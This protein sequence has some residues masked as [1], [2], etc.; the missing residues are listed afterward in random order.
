MGTVPCDMDKSSRMLLQTF[1][2]AIG[3]FTIMVET[4]TMPTSNESTVSLT[5]S[6]YPVR[7]VLHGRCG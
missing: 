3:D 2:V 1:L 6:A 7:R 4:A 5:Q